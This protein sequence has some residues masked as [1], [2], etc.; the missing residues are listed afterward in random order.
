MNGHDCNLE[1]KNGQHSDSLKLQNGLVHQEAN[2]KCMILC[3]PIKEQPASI[4]QIKEKCTTQR[5]ESLVSVVWYS[6]LKAFSLEI[7]K[8][9]PV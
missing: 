7:F 9:F 1:K 5:K 8:F 2:K 3:M 4:K 6:G